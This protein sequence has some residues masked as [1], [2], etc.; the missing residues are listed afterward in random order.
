MQALNRKLMEQLVQTA[1][2]SWMS[3]TALSFALFCRSSSAIC[4]LGWCQRQGWEEEDRHLGNMEMAPVKTREVIISSFQI[5]IVIGV[6]R[7]I[8]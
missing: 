7:K 6:D 3:T 8:P 1:Q 4:G 2:N 5:W